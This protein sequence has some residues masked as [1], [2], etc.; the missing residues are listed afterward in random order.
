MNNISEQLVNIV[1]L[2]KPKILIG[3][4][5]KGTQSVNLFQTEV[6]R[7]TGLPVE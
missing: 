7:T 6:T 3:L 2:N 1:T 4:T 5:Q